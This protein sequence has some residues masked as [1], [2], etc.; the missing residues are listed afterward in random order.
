M[1][2]TLQLDGKICFVTGSTRGI[3]WACAQELARAGARVVLNGRSNPELLERRIAELNSISAGPHLALA[4]DISDPSQIRDFYQRIFSNY[5]RLDVLVN[6]AGIIADGLLGM[7]PADLVDRVLHVNTAA[8]IL[9]M[10]EAARLMMRHQSGSIINLSS[11]MGVRGH[12][13]LSVYSASKAAVIGATYAAAK[14]L[15]PRGIRV[16]AVAPGF[17]DTDM[18]RQLP[19]EKFRERLGTVKMNRVGRPEEV[20]AVVLFLASAMSSYVTGQVIGV[21]GGMTV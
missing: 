16:N 18:A 2:S 21:D 7:I 10:Q 14:E 19:A 9:N 4:G 11:I 1:E 5:K 8:V 12:A 3:G 13:G 20:A 17:I 6:N 15:A